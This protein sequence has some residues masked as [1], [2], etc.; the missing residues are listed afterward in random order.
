MRQRNLEK[1]RHR[2]DGEQLAPSASSAPLASSLATLSAAPCFPP[3]NV[4]NDAL[5]LF[6]I[7][8]RIVGL[9]VE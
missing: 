4:L 1:R 6:Q 3:K 5:A 7:F 2:H 9:F 8:F